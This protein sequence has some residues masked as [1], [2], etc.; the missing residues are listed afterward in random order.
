MGTKFKKALR[1]MWPGGLRTAFFF[2]PLALFLA[3]QMV[4]PELGNW[5]LTSKAMAASFSI[6][7]N[8]VA[9][10]GNFLV[11]RICSGTTTKPDP[12][13]VAA[14]QQFERDSIKQYL[15]IYQISSTDNDVNFIYSYARTELRTALRAF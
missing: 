2:R 9:A 1:Y 6:P 3:L 15:S 13:I 8:C 4:P 12:S 10:G 14:I 5:S 7:D 11:Q